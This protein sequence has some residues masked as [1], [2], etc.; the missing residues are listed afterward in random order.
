[1][2]LAP[3]RVVA[4]AAFA[5]S[6]P[7]A[8]LVARRRAGVD[9]RRTGTGTVSGSGLY[10]LAG[11]GP[12]A[13]TGGV[14]LAKGALGPLLAGRARPLL[15]ALAAAA[16][17]VGH[18]WSPFLGLK[19]G[20]GVSLAVGAGLVMAPEAALGLLGGL[21]AGRLVR[22]SGLGTLAGLVSL[23]VLVARRRGVVG[24]AAGG[25]LVAPILVKRLLGND[26]RLPATATVAASRML[27][28]R[29][30]WPRLARRV[31]RGEVGR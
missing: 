9:L 26:A 22:E 19:G 1:M 12:L 7:V 24:G 13:A 21:G 28:D 23:P 15:G 3:S 30:D 8:N 25:L 20:R 14:E 11:F 16:A 27:A 6:V 18:N 29:D 2:T 4:V 31:G 10:A 17:I 5:G